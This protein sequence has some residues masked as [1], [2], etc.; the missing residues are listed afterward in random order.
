[1]KIQQNLPQQ[2]QSWLQQVR[3]ADQ[4]AADRDLR[5]DRVDLTAPGLALG[6]DEDR[7]TRARA[8]FDR[9]GTLG[10]SLTV[11]THLDAFWIS[12]AKVK[13]QREGDWEQVQVSLHHPRDPQMFD[14]RAS[15][16]RHLDS[17]EIRDAQVVPGPPE[18]LELVREI[19]TDKTSQLTMAGGGAVGALAGS[20]L[21]VG[22]AGPLGGAA[23]GAGLAYLFCVQERA[24]GI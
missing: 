9:R 3:Q 20:L 13:V 18:G 7:V 8:G 22:L 15:Y 11:D 21:G 2:V 19:F 12:E 24:Y 1:M 17:G 16:A 6:Q 4:S 5:P 10:A 14:Y 23:A